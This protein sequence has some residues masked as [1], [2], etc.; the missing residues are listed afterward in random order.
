[1]HYFYGKRLAIFIQIESSACQIAQ[2]RQQI[3]I[4]LAFC[5]FQGHNNN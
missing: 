1:L 2:I 5:E 3:P 4:L